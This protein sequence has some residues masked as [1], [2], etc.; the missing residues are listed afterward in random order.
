MYFRTKRSGGF[1]YL[2]MVESHRVN[3]KPRQTVLATLGRLDALKETGELER[4]L[5][6][7]ARL[8]ETG[9]LLSGVE[10]GETTTIDA[11]R[12]GPPLLFERLWRDSSCRSVIEHLLADRKFEFPVER[13]VFLTVLHRIMDP[14]SDRAAEKWRSA[15]SIAGMDAIDLHHLYRAMAWLGEELADQQGSG[16]VPRTNKDL[17][18]E[19]LFA[20]R[21][22]LFN[23]VGLAIFD[24]TSLY[25]EGD[26]GTTLGRHGHSKDSRPDLH[27]MVL[28]VVIDETGRPI[29]SEMWPGN[30][31]DVTTLIPVVTRLRE[32]F[33]LNRV[34]VIADRGM[35]SAKT[36]ATLEAEKIEY[37]LGVR[38][39][40]SV[41]IAA[42]L[43]DKTPFVSL[44][45]P[46]A[47]GRGT[48]DLQVKEVVR[49]VKAG[50]GNTRRCRYIVCYNEAE[51]RNDA[52]AREA[53]LAGLEKALRQGDKALVGNKGFRRF[54]KIEADCHFAIDPDRVAAAAKFDGIYVIR[55]NA[56]ISPLVVALRY[57]E[58]WIV[59]D[60][61]RTAKSII[62]TR[63]IFH[64]RDDTIRGHVFCSF[65]ALLLRK[66]LIDRL[67][68]AGR[69]LEWADIIH[70]LDQLVQTDVDQGGRRL[71][72]RAAAPGCSGAVFQAVGVAL[73]PMIRITAQPPPPSPARSADP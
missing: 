56:Q 2:Q 42:V 59:E 51:A 49:K 65:L 10:N 21:R 15:Y 43:A 38:E 58:R 8:T 40:R 18:E 29:C 31:A 70:D 64:Q 24:T 47:N 48:L 44:T 63:P 36:V 62:N 46:K 68:A 71:R 3:G 33:L 7:G 66:E 50:Q 1:E 17:I 73:P 30:T 39:K 16:L 22:S 52:A 14:G 19:Q 57:R 4:L 23:D 11:K 72:L 41:E 69:R 32:R 37:I 34:C 54:L 67:V 61:F 60:I 20:K 28:G 26:G 12:I 27:Q 53:A 45:V 35:V 55:T 6:S 5:R 13:A 25:F 9:M